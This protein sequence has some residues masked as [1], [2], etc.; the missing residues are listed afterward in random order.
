MDLVLNRVGFGVGPRIGWMLYRL[1][2]KCE[3]IEVDGADCQYGRY[4]CGPGVNGF[5]TL[6][7]R[8]MLLLLGWK[9]PVWFTRLV[10]FYLTDGGHVPRFPRKSIIKVYIN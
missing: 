4:N 1:K 2:T 6:S 3:L 7:D 5:Q 8:S 9:P 10:P